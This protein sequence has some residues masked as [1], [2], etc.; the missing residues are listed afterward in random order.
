MYVEK[1]LALTDEEV[2]AGLLAYEAA[3]ARLVA[4]ARPLTDSEPLELRSALGRVLAKPVSSA[5]NARRIT[6][7]NTVMREGYLFLLLL[8][9]LAEMP[10]G[11][12]P[13]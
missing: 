3:V 10:R 2:A 12:R 7:R 4:A 1:P 5:I 11:R 8:R 9:L 6:E 13:V